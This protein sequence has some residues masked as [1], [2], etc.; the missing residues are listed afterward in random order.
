MHDKGNIRDQLQ[1]PL[2]LFSGEKN[3]VAN[4]TEFGTQGIGSS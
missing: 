1:E 4:K 3:H 2:R